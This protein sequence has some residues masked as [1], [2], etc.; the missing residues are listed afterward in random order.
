MNKLSYKT[1]SDKEKITSGCPD[2]CIV[3]DDKET[4]NFFDV[5]ELNKSSEKAGTYAI[6][7]CACGEAGCN[8][9]EVEV[10]HQ[11]GEIVWQKMWH[12]DWD[13]KSEEGEQREFSFAENLIGHPHLGIKPPFRFNEKEYGELVKKLNGRNS[14]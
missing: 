11:D 14:E 2:F 8:G 6:V 5:G 3:I 12:I 7:T 9:S 10:I 1:I 4:T 13:G